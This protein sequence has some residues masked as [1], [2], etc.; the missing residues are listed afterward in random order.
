MRRIEKN[1]ASKCYY[2]Q[3]YIYT[4]CRIKLESKKK[5]KIVNVSFFIIF[6]L[7]NNFRNIYNRS[8]R[9]VFNYNTLVELI[10]YKQFSDSFSM[11]KIE[12]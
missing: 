12:I 3:I 2:V 11:I 4:Q 9:I 8:I 5:Y 6:F 1:I 10:R 7:Q